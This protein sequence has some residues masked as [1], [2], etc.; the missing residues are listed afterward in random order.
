MTDSRD[1]KPD[2]QTGLGLPGD[3][4]PDLDADE[5]DERSMDAE[6]AVDTSQDEASTLSVPTLSVPP[7]QA[8]STVRHQGE[9]DA[10]ANDRLLSQASRMPHIP[11]YQL[12]KKLGQGGMGAVYLAM[13]QKLD[14]TWPSK[15]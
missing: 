13:D 3:L 12:V 7:T 9:T 6:A 2:P 14:D 15:W 10:A 11:G 8:G 4:P 1:A 5:F